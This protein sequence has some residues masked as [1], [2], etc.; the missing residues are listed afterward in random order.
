MNSGSVP[1]SP[2]HAGEPSQES[3]AEYD[4]ARFAIFL[5]GVVRNEPLCGRAVY[6]N[7]ADLGNILRIALEGDMP[8]RPEL[9]VAEREWRGLITPD[10]QHGCDYCLIVVKDWSDGSR[11]A[12]KAEPRDR[13]EDVSEADRPVDSRDSPETGGRWR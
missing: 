13:G 10:C 9:I 8:G 5:G 6:Q 11:R 12:P 7:D 2:W 3:L 1:S 4:R